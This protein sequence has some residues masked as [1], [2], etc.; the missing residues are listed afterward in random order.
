MR[1]DTF[2]PSPPRLSIVIPLREDHPLLE[3]CLGVLRDGCCRDSAEIIVATPVSG[4]MGDRLSDRGCRVVA[5][6]L[7]RGACLAA[8]IREAAGKWILVVHADTVLSNDWGTIVQMFMDTNEGEDVAA[9]FRFRQDS[10]SLK[11]RCL[12]TLVNLRCAFFALPYGDQG[13]LMTRA[14]YDRIGGYRSDFPL[15]EDVDIVRRIGR[16]RLRRLEATAV[17]SAERYGRGYGRRVLRNAKC[18]ALYFRGVHPREI[19]K[20][21]ERA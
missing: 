5:A 14:F 13:L 1:I 17:T 8:G 12:E 7:G 15:M 9:Y 16:A 10:S 19:V 2:M 20:L 21:Y 3:R 4:E 18:L 6:P 11:S